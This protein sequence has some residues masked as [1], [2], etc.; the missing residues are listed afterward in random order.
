MIK[1]IYIVVE[2]DNAQLLQDKVN[3]SIQT[4]NNKSQ[5]INIQYLD[6]I[7]TPQGKYI[8]TLLVSSMVDSIGMS[9]INELLNNKP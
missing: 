5:M 7:I 3:I 2:A 8:Q 1:E 9:G 4:F 6:L